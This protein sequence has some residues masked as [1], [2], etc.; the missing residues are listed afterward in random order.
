MSTYFLDCEFNG[1]GGQLLSLALVEAVG[2]RVIVPEAPV[3]HLYMT[4][5]HDGMTI[6]P[7]VAEN[8]LPIMSAIPEGYEQSFPL[9]RRVAAEMIRDFLTADPA[10]YIVTD[11]PDDVRYFCESVITAPGEMVSIPSLRFEVCRV[12]AYP[13]RLN[14]AVQHN[15]L[16]DALAL[17]DLLLKD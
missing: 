13:S 16:W 4:F 11:W 15:A 6:E 8:V 10:P 17:R 3:R 9:N 1:F 2:S 14:D 5:A 12:D 7:W